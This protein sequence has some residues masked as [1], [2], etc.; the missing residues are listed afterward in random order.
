MNMLKTAGMKDE[1]EEA[2]KPAGQ[3]TAAIATVQ[4]GHTPST[5]RPESLSNL[6]GQMFMTQTQQKECHITSLLLTR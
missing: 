1:A 4:N 6:Q 3:A 5:A 2:S